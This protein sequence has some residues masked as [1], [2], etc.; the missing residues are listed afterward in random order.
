MWLQ[1][2]VQRA[3]YVDRGRDIILCDRN[4]VGERGGTLLLNISENAILRLRH[5]L[6][7]IEEA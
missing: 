1:I 2:E 6:H 3:L 4:I 5:E 7:E